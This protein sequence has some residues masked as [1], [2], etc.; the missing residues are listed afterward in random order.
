MPMTSEQRREDRYE[1]GDMCL[2]LSVDGRQIPEI[3]QTLIDVS[4]S[5][6]GIRVAG[7]VKVG[8]TVEFRLGLAGGQ[9]AGR[10]RVQWVRDCGGGFRCGVKISMGLLDRIRLRSFLN[11]IDADIVETLDGILFVATSG[12]VFL[13]AVK[14]LGVE[15]A[16][17]SEISHF[18]FG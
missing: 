7:F 18:Y 16:S 12:V 14:F 13:S 11:P 4:C 9:V 1:R 3:E 8:Q 10:G 15:I 17:L 2:A 5:G 6:L